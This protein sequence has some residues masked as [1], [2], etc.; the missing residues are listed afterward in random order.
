MSALIILFL[1]ATNHMAVWAAQIAG[2]QNSWA[3]SLTSPFAHL[4]FKAV[5]MHQ[6]NLLPCTS[7]PTLKQDLSLITGGA[8]E[9]SN[10]I[11]LC[12]HKIRCT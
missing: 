7:P 9:N 12:Y 6:Q 11:L 4:I 1:F 10:D 8:F 5:F 2:S 3:P